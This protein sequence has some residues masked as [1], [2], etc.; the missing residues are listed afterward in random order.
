MPG[1]G[2]FRFAPAFEHTRAVGGLTRAVQLGLHS[3]GDEVRLLREAAG[4]RWREPRINI[5]IVRQLR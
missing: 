2:G 5:L 1:L 4:D 3:L